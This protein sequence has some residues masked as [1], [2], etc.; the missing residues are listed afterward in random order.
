M[1][2]FFR[3]AA[4][5]SSSR[6]ESTDNS[7][8]ESDSSGQ[9]ITRVRTLGSSTAAEEQSEP[10]ATQTLDQASRS[11]S[12]HRD[13]LL[14]ALLEE[15]C[16]SEALEDLKNS[17]VNVEKS[18][19]QVDTLAKEKYARLSRQLGRYG[20]ETGDLNS[21]QFGPLRQTYRDGL[22]VITRKSVDLQT[23][24]EE[25]LA[26]SQG[27]NLPGPLLRLMG[28]NEH[29]ATIDMSRRFSDLAIAGSDLHA[30]PKLLGNGI[31]P[32][33]P[34]LNSTRYTRDFEEFGI[35]G[36]G[37]YGT[38]FRCKH[39]LDGRHYAIKKIPLGPSRM[40]KIQEN[41][42]AELDHILVEVR[43]LARLEHP[44]IVRY[45]S[46]WIEWAPLIS[47]KQALESN[48]HKLLE[49]PKESEEEDET[50]TSQGYSGRPDVPAIDV[51]FGYDDDEDP[52]E[53]S[54]GQSQRFATQEEEG[55]YSE[56]NPL[57]KIPSR[58]T[59][60]SVS[61]ESEVEVITRRNYPS[62]S[63]YDTSSFTNNHHQSNEPSLALHIQM[64]LYS[65]T[66]SDFLAPSVYP[67]GADTNDFSSLRH[68]FHAHS[69]L[70]I[71]ASVI[72]G[73]EYLHSEGIVHRDL[74]PGNIFLAVREGSKPP[75]GALSLSNC[76]SCLSVNTHRPFNISIC[77]GDFGLV[78]S[79]AR[80]EDEPPPTV[81]ASTKAVGTE[82][83]R[84]YTVTRNN[85]PCLDVYALGIIAFELL[86]RFGTRMERH[87]MLHR[88]KKGELAKELD[89][90][91]G[92]RGMQ[93]WILNM[94]E[95]N[96]SDCPTWEQL[97]ESLQKMLE[98]CKKSQGKG[99]RNI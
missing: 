32:G 22:S 74:K 20:L 66:L 51:Q 63:S 54:T 56:G 3:S 61:D 34:L 45:H 31:L 29:S 46:G 38:V 12:Y 8:D 98:Q 5:I 77:I 70:E 44:N 49:A 57:Q 48:G 28:G 30:Q 94:V 67:V 86:H 21:E 95:A 88:L 93:E 41:G 18:H 7:S 36:K 55:S 85:H 50:S 40:R 69:S 83:Y 65:M 92:C 11:S 59:V 33:H 52:F 89:D 53:M 60:A 47:N 68:C 62:E 58:S 6:E 43:T 14:H 78:S 42:Q 76:S 10:G 9:Q 13:L 16:Y 35:L 39:N 96:E 71:L 26:Q 17:G 91:I 82:I 25:I 75:P 1:S 23:P 79:I 24:I 84:P 64:S 37:G 19:P 97:R 27:S 73:V 99:K 72:E 87:E 81:G 15:R 80:P 4:D 2:S 90:D